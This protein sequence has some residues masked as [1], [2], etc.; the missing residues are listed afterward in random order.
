MTTT[1]LNIPAE[2]RLNVYEQLFRSIAVKVHGICTKQSTDKHERNTTHLNLFLRCRTVRDE[3][4]QVFLRCATLK[5][6]RCMPFEV[7]E[8]FLTG[9]T[10]GGTF[11]LDWILSMGEFVFPSFD[12]RD[13]L[14]DLSIRYLCAARRLIVPG[15]IR[16]VQE[17]YS[18]GKFRRLCTFTMLT[19]CRPST[20]HP[21][22]R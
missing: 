6:Y 5:L 15:T 8:V 14:G 21:S 11:G 12:L 22:H 20:C 3:F 7:E 1:W 16:I 10:K 9:A 13:W 2:D 17:Q 4:R 19:C 18:K